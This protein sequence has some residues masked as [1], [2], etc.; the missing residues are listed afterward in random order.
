MNGRSESKIK[1]PAKGPVRL[2]FIGAA[3][4]RIRRFAFSDN[5]LMR[6][7]AVDE[8]ILALAQRVDVLIKDSSALTSS[9]KVSTGEPMVAAPF[10]KENDSIP[11]APPTL[12]AL[13]CYEKPD[14]TNA[15]QV[16][17]RM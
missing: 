6:I 3:N 9:W 13:P 1:I 16:D 11:L 4:A 10:V 12:N 15:R 14:A 5:L 7:L 8:I 2:G 17:I